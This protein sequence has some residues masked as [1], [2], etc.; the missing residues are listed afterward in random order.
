MVAVIPIASLAGNTRVKREWQDSEVAMGCP[1][2]EKKNGSVSFQ[3]ERME[4]SFPQRPVCIAL[5]LCSQPTTYH[6]H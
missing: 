3:L 5:P 2:R 1:T 4:L 6:C